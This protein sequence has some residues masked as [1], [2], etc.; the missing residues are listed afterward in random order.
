MTNDLLRFII[1]IFEKK[2]QHANAILNFK[3]PVEQSSDYLMI[4]EQYFG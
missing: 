1:Y 2:Q 3:S 4:K